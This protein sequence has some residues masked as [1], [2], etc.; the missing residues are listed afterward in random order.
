MNIKEK[1][2]N[3]QYRFLGEKGAI[4]ICHWTKK[5][6]LNEGSCYKQKFYGIPAHM[7]A[8]ISPIALWCSNNCIYCWRPMEFMKLKH[9]TKE[10]VDNPQTIIEEAVKKRR[11]LLIGF[12]GNKY[13]CKEKV[14]EIL[15][16]FPDHW[17]I[18]LSGE[19]LLYPYLLEN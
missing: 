7:C 15:E 11:E 8:Q 6:I 17:A 19:P 3:M 10:E 14:K 12:K 13:A 5:A 16:E 9:F 1:L 18:S 4:E 2:E